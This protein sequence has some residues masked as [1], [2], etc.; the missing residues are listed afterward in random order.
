[1]THHKWTLCAINKDLTIFVS[2]ILNISFWLSEK[3]AATRTKCCAKFLIFFSWYDGAFS[4]QGKGPRTPL[5]C[6]R[7]C[8]QNA[9][10]LARAPCPF[11]V[12]LRAYRSHAVCKRD[13]CV[14]KSGPYQ[15]GPEERSEW[16]K[17]VLFCS[18]WTKVNLKHFLFDQF[19]SEFSRK[20]SRRSKFVL[21]QTHS[22]N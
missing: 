12:G 14:H 7:S 20:E 5:R 9:H 18:S 6:T 15:S 17:C 1:M 8:G 21:Q 11:C 19:V 4:K 10:D 22:L 16:N 3:G 2:I 13:L